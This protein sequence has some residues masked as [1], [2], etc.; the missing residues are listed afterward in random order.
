MEK[1]KRSFTLIELVIT[2]G[3]MAIAIGITAGVLVATTKSYQKQQLI[4][5]VTSNGDRV[6]R[7]LEEKIRNANIVYC[8]KYDDNASDKLNP[9]TC[10]SDDIYN[11]S[12]F[13]VVKTAATNGFFGIYS[14][15]PTCGGSEKSHTMFYTEDVNNL[16]LLTPTQGS[17]LM[18]DDDYTGATINSFKMDINSSGTSSNVIFDMDIKAGLCSGWNNSKQFSTFITVRGSY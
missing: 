17:K 16:S 12:T 4:E 6:I 11:G 7:T 10:L 14:Q 15:D 5:S 2:I 18:K 8:A 9:V 3:V 13:I 1:L